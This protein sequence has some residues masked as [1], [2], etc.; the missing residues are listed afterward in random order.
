MVSAEFASKF[1]PTKAS[2]GLAL[3]VPPVLR[4]HD[5]VGHVE[6]SGSI[7]LFS[8]TSSYLTRMSVIMPVCATAKAMLMVEMLHP[9]IKDN[10]DFASCGD[11]CLEATSSVMRA[12][13]LLFQTVIAGDSWGLIAVPL[14]LKH[15]ETAIIF[16]LSLLTL[17]FGVLRLAAV[18]LALL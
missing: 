14:I 7:F 8:S 17:V 12:N 9:L 6:A 3:V 4:D 2:A 5:P 11:L 16:V 13:L 18:M 15:P 10:P 1:G